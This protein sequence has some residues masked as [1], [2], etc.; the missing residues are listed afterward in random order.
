QDLNSDKVHRSRSG[1]WFGVIILLIVIGLAGAGYYFL[2]SLRTKQ[3]GLGGEVKGEIAKQLQDY[4]A[5]LAAIQSQ[6]ANINKEMSSKDERFN[7]TL[8]NF[9]TLH[10]DQLNATRKE[11]N[12]SIDRIQRQLG[13]TRGDWLISDAEYL[14][15]VA[16]ERLH[17]IGDVKTALEALEG[18]DQR[19]RE[20]GDTGVIKVREQIA[21]E[22]STI[23][24]LTPP[25]MVGT[26]VAI[27]SQ[28]EQV[29]KL[30][31]L[32]PYAG[33][34]VSDKQGNTDNAM[35]DMLGVK[36][37]EQPIEAIL[38]T[39]EAKFIYEQLRVKLE[40]AEIALVQQHD[41]LYQSA[42]DDAKNWL[43]KQFADN[44]VRQHFAK[45]LDKFKAIKIRSQFP[46]ISVSLKML[47]DIS[48]LRIEADKSA[49]SETET[50][51][52]DTKPTQ[53]APETAT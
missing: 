20:S 48:K 44:E 36:Y 35:L 8:D 37:S 47:K 51:K 21:Q 33:K 53:V 16:N 23:K 42:L 18:A 45:E 29:D 38:T 19:L 39:E 5:Q 28:Q 1:F 4:Q 27:Q 7:K 34:P 14:L 31:L 11:F 12:D 2:Q 52:P 40:I 26:Y 24:N 3:E 49:Q 10:K 30:T 15:S 22:I 46:D 13:K 32:R 6:L 17:L 9:S 41:E 25:D 43:E 50:K